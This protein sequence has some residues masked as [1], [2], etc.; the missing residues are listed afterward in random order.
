MTK[1]PKI[2]FVLY[3]SASS[4]SSLKATRNLLCLLEDYA[5]G[6]VRLR[7]R[8]L[9]KEP[10]GVGDEDRVTFTPTLVKRTPAPRAW[11]VGD[12]ENISYVVD[13]I[14]VAGAEKRSHDDDREAANPHPRPGRSE[15]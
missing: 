3:V 8:D 5:A 10:I 15:R 11:V 12:L 4:P 14:T 13:M 7:I 2:D 9:S 6:E 1:D